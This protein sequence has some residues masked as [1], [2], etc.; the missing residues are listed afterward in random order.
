MGKELLARLG[1]ALTARASG[2]ADQA[3]TRAHF[4]IVIFF[5]IKKDPAR[6]AIET[7]FY[8]NPASIGVNTVHSL[9]HSEDSH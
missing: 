2:L 5:T 9:L 4:S 8:W 1:T 6:L 3:S 7:G